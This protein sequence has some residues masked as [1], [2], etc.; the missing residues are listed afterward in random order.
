MSICTM[1][2]QMATLLVNHPDL[3]PPEALEELML[4][5]AE[6]AFLRKLE[7]STRD[8]TWH[9]CE[10]NGVSIGQQIP[11]APVRKTTGVALE[12]DRLTEAIRTELSQL[13]KLQV[14][15]IVSEGAA[16]RIGTRAGHTL[17]FC[18]EG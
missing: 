1:S 15:D 12:I 16:R 2:R 4:I 7:Q 17:G 14:A 5:H 3:D 13:T 18:K 8:G 10:W 11:A 6:K 9:E